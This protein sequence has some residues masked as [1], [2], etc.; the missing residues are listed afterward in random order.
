MKKKG[1]GLVLTS[2]QEDED[3]QYFYR[4]IGYLDC[5]ELNLP[6]PGYEQPRELILG[7]G[8]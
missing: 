2:T 6:F 7:K 8:L 3:A 1:H 4:A 5:G